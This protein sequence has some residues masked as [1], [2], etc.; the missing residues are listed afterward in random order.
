MSQRPS[1]PKFKSEAE[2]ARWWFDHRKETATWME[3]AAAEGSLTNLK[4]ILGRRQQTGP[5]PTVSIRIDPGDLS[6]AR[7]LAERRGLRYQ[8]YL[9]M[10]LHEALEQEHRRMAG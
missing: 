4:E 7:A 5:T 1:I 6:L 9:K 8:T 2:E 10:L 3:K